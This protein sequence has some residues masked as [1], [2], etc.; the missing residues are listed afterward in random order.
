M[1]WNQDKGNNTAE[2]ALRAGPIKKTVRGKTKQQEGGGRGEDG[3]K[4]GP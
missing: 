2:G 3:A 1:K 4:Q